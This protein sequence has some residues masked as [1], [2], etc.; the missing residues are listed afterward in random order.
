METKNEK[1]DTLLEHKQKLT[2]V[3][4]ALL[5]SQLFLFSMVYF[6]KNHL[7]SFDFT[8]P[9]DGG[10]PLLVGVFAMLSTTT[11]IISFVM[12]NRM[13]EQAVAEQNVGM[14][15][16]AL[17]IAYALCESVSLLGFLLALT[18]E[19]QY[20]FIWFAVGIVGIILHFP[21]EKYLLA[22]TFKK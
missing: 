6:L 18:I 14:L 21:K 16:S 19:Y 4:A 22:V 13:I 7:I 2:I 17:I 9:L 15:Q 20:F 3:W 10:N 1:P 11:F 12:R 8:K 5:F